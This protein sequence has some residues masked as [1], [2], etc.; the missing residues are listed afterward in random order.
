MN[1]QLFPKDEKLLFFLHVSASVPTVLQ[2]EMLVFLGSA[3]AFLVRWV[4]FCF[5]W[6][7]KR[8]QTKRAPFM[9]MRPA[10]KAPPKGELVKG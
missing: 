10:E 8:P 9:T 4:W 6:K 1:T 2:P 7:S 3:Q 5:S